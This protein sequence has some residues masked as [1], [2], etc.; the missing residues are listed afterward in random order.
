M[1]RSHKF[2]WVTLVLSVLLSSAKA[3]GD[4]VL[5]ECLPSGTSIFIGPFDCNDEFLWAA[6][7]DTCNDF[8]DALGETPS[9]C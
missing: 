7:K 2:V 3:F 8:C 1:E 9:L 6:A 5:C 4:T